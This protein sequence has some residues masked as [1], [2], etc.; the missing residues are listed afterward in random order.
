MYTVV[1]GTEIHFGGNR[2]STTFLP[3]YQSGGF[4]A[5][6]SEALPTV[7][8]RAVASPRPIRE[9]SRHASLLNLAFVAF[10]GPMKL[11]IKHV[12]PCI[13]CIRRYA[14]REQLS[15][16]LSVQGVRVASTRLFLA[17]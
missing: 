2:S 4:D 1:V 9:V 16:C 14:R 13:P 3:P 17:F 8:T 10:Q 15:R 5:S 7:E 11:T 6:E 12:Q